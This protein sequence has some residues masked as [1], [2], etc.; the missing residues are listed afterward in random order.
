VKKIIFGIF[1]FL[2]LLIIQSISPK[3]TLAA[4][5][6]YYHAC[7]RAGIAQNNCSPG[8]GDEWDYFTTQRECDSRY[9]ELNTYGYTCNSGEGIQGYDGGGKPILIPG[10]CSL[11]GNSIRCRGGISQSIVNSTFCEAV[12]T[13]PTPPRQ[14]PTPTPTLRTP[15]P[16]PSTP[17]PGQGTCQNV[18]IYFDAPSYTV[19]QTVKTWVRGNIPQS[20]GLTMVVNA[21]PGGAIINPA[22]HGVTGSGSDNT[23]TWSFPLQ[24][25]GTYMVYTYSKGVLCPGS[26]SISVRAPSAGQGPTCNISATPESG[27][28]PLAVNLTANAFA[29]SGFTINQSQWNFGYTNQPPKYYYTFSPTISETASQ[30]F[31]QN[32]NVT[33]TATDSSGMST[34]C[35]KYIAIT[36]S[37]VPTP[38]VSANTVYMQNL[39]FNPN[40]INVPMGQAVTWYNRDITNHTVTSIDGRFPNSGII[41]PGQSYTAYFTQPGTFPYRCDFHPLTMTGTVQVGT[42]GIGGP[43]PGDPSRPTCQ[44]SAP[45][46]GPNGMTVT[47]T[48]Q[49]SSPAGRAIRQYWF[50]FGISGGQYSQTPTGTYTY[51]TIG[52]YRVSSYV[53]D[54]VGARSDPC[55][56]TDFYVQP[57]VPT[58]YTPPPTSCTQAIQAAFR[59]PQSGN[60]WMNPAGI[61]SSTFPFFNISAQLGG[62]FNYSHITDPNQTPDPNISLRV[63]GPNNYNEPFTN[64]AYFTPPTGGNYTL[65]ATSRFG[66]CSATATLVADYATPTPTPPYF[67]P[68]PTPPYFYPT[69]T[70]PYFYPTPTP[71]FTIINPYDNSWSGP[72]FSQP[73]IDNNPDSS[74]P[75]I[76]P[77]PTPYS[78]QPYSPEPETYYRPLPYNWAP[79]YPQP[80]NEGPIYDNSIYSHPN[81]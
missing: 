50:D 15:P 78:A 66:G 24:R 2:F 16:P 39:T 9:R 53:I 5:T 43:L 45:Q 6:D 59:S 58:P 26:R 25:E 76:Y 13:T 38:P 48:N 71:D 4:K 60:V 42:G 36:G 79:S 11:D 7:C 40:Y 77:S 35:S 62:F 52:R 3:V 22:F 75:Y 44:L 70:P 17:T 61:T 69:P 49:A 55:V 46:I 81:I 23:W 47:V 74:Q 8:T 21:Y 32:T 28:S 30:T 67:Y 12:P 63:T 73:A 37:P 34:T 41:G 68:T 72:E 54:E 27:S 29:S 1:C 10:V 18:N 65:Y 19:G 20:A 33:F 56:S 31:Y 51:P 80:S 64:G 14:A 57:A